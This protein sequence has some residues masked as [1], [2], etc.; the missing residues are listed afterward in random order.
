MNIQETDGKKEEK[1]FLEKN[2]TPASWGGR[3]TAFLI[4]A[5]FITLLFWVI[6]A[7]IYPLIAWANLYP[8]LNF[9]AI[10]LGI[11]IVFYFTFM[12]TKWGSTLGKGLLRLK[13]KAKDGKMDYRKALIRNIPKFLWFPLIIDI[14]L[15]SMGNEK[16]RYFDTLANTVVIKQE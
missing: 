3:I 1:T 6:T 15:G 5:I 11:V 13:V 10:F 16:N 8:I 7:V 12:E 14:I 9:W 2:E 4:D